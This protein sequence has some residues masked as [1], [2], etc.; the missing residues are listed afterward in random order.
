MAPRAADAQTEEALS[1][2]DHD[3]VEGVLTGQ[4]LGNVVGSD[5]PGQKHRGRDQ[6]SGG[7]IATVLVSGQ[8]LAD[9]VGIGRIGIERPD[10]I[11]PIRPGIR[12]LSV[13]LETMRVGVAH[14]IEPLLPP[15][16]SVGRR[17]QQR[18]HHAFGGIR[19]RVLLEGQSLFRGRRKAGEI[20]VDP[21]KPGDAV[22]LG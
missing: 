10:H 7:G 9:E 15:V 14:H 21:A 17:L 3:F 4:A 1:G 5:L 11:V 22:G 18:L 16:L 20:E 12:A 13:D 19:A 2:V 8:L 6:K